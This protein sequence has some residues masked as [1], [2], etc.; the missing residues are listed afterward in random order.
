MYNEIVKV[1]PTD[2]HLGILSLYDRNLGGDGHFFMYSISMPT[3]IAIAEKTTISISYALIS[4]TSFLQR[5]K[6]A[7]VFLSVDNTN[8]IIT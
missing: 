8:L 2:G 5:G 4:T 7:T 1:L 3:I 6:E